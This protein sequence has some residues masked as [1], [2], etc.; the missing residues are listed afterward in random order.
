VRAGYRGTPTWKKPARRRIARRILLAG[1]V[2]GLGALA[3]PVAAPPAAFS[4][5]FRS[6]ACNR[7]R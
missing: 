4:G 7:W 2:L 6:S 1:A 5:R 3:V